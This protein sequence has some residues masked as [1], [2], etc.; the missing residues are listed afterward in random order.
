MIHSFDLTLYYV[1]IT[2]EAL[3]TV[4]FGVHAGAQWRGALWDT[5]HTFACN[6]PT[7]QG[8]P[9]HSWHCPACFIL[10]L[11]AES[12]RGINPPRPLVIRPSLSVRADEDCTFMIGESFTLDLILVGEALNVFPYLLQAVQVVGQNGIGF[13]RGCFNLRHV[14][15]LNPLTKTRSVVYESGSSVRMPNLPITNTQVMQ[16]ANNLSNDHLR[17]HFLTPT[18]LVCDGKLLLRPQPD[19]L[20]MRT[21]E[22]LQSLEYHYGQPVPQEIWKSRH[23]TLTNLATAIHIRRDETHWICSYS[24]SRR[25]DRMQNL[26]GFVGTVTLEGNL[27][28]LRLWLLWASLVNIGKNAIKGNGWLEVSS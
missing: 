17:L 11:E 22:R 8:E 1:R 3:T 24:G 7:H 10:A 27:A 20:V 14:E 26:S 9:K 25:A 4:H 6:D 12:P 16:E 18:Q 5:L 13:G 28:Q 21:L 19:I 15:T 2:C 23:E